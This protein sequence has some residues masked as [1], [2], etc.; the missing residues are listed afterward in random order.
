[1][2]NVTNFIENYYRDLREKAENK[3]KHNYFLANQN[4]EFMTNESEINSLIIAIAKAEVLGGDLNAL[5]QNLK[6]LKAKNSKILN[7][8][9]LK[10]SDIIPQYNCKF[11]NDTGFID[12]K[13]CDCRKVLS[14]KLILDE[15]GITEIPLRTFAD[16]DEKL[17]P[18]INYETY[19]RYCQNFDKT[20]TKTLIF[21]GK[22]GTGK[23]F[24]AECIASEIKKQN[25][26]VVFISAFALNKLF[27]DSFNDANK[28]NAL[29][30]C[31]LLVIDD[32]GSEQIFKKITKEYLLNLLNE[33]S[34][35]NK[36]LII[37]TNLTK[38]DILNRYED[39][40]FSRL[41]D[42][43]NSVYIPFKSNVDLRLNKK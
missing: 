33:R 28:L 12:G 22:S 2:D 29:F 11:C 35:Y 19:K 30:S 20:K 38:D 3:A 13:V 5:K 17:T 27:V 37:T 31:D 26:S 25:K 21:S 14:N 18:Y 8:L 34:Y 10:E 32:F 41:L 43:S 15:V 6:K 4:A 42:K 23:T 9:G 36:N 16:A 24:L 1:M 39:R 40:I 7:D